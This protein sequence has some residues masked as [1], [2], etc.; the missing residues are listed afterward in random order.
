M[1]LSNKNGLCVEK[2]R[3]REEK[4]KEGKRERERERGRERYLEREEESES[5]RDRELRDIERMYNFKYFL[6]IV[7]DNIFLRQCY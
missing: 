6:S 1:G 2:K 4:N 3:R 7:D 5:H